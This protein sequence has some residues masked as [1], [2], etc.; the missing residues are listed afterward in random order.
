M[1][2]FIS[3]RF[4]TSAR[5]NLIPAWAKGPP[6]PTAPSLPSASPALNQGHPQP[7]HSRRPSTLGEG[8]AFKDGVA[9]A[10]SPT[11]AAKPGTAASVIARGAADR[12]PASAVT[13]GQI[14][15]V[16][17][18]I[19]SSPASVPTI[20]SATVSSF[21]PVPA[22][23]TSAPNDKSTGSSTQPPTSAT[24]QSKF[25]VKKLFAN[26]S[27]A[28]PVSSAPSQA[29]PDDASPST[30][31]SP[32]P[33]ALRPEQNGGLS[34]TPQLVPGPGWYGGYYYQPYPG[35]PPEHY[36]PS[37]PWMQAH[38]GTPH[39]QPQGLPGPPQP[40]MPMSPRNAP[41]QLHPPGTPTMAPAMPNPGHPPH[42]A[43][44]P[45]T[46]TSS[47]SSISSPPP[48]PS[49]SGP[50][51]RLNTAAPSFQPRTRVKITS[52]DGKE[53]QL[54]SFKKG[55]A[56]L[57][58]A[59]PASPARKTTVRLEKAKRE[60]P[61]R[62]KKEAVEKAEKEAEEKVT[63][64]GAEP[65]EV[66]VDE[67][68]AT[69]ASETIEKTAD[70]GDFNDKLQGNGILR[71]DAA[72][73]D[74][75]K[76]RHPGPLDLS[77]TRKPIAQTFPSAL[78][79]ARIIE[80]L[81]SV[82]Y[83]EGIRSPKVELNVNAKHGKFRYDRDFLM[84]F[85]KICKDK[86]DNLLRLDAIG[87]EP[88]EQGAG[89]PMSRGGSQRRSSAAM[90]PPPPELRAPAAGSWS[91]ELQW[92]GRQLHHGKV[93]DA[94]P[95]DDMPFE[96]RPSPMVWLPSEAGPSA[97]GSKSTRCKR[98]VDCG[99]RDKGGP[100]PSYGDS[101]LSQPGMISLEPVA[102]LEQSAN[103]WTPLSLTD[104]PEVVERRVRGLLNKLTTERF[105]SISDQIIAWANRS[106]N[107][108]DGRTLFQIMQ[109]VVESATDGVAL[110]GMYARLCRKMMNQ[111]SPK[112]QDEGIKN[113]EGKPI[114]G[115][116]LFRKYLLN[117][118][119]EDFERGWV[120]KESTAATKAA[121]DW[122]AAEKDESG[123][124]ASYS[125][126][127]YAAQ[128]ARRQ[129][130]GLIK[131][132]GELFKL[133][134]LTQRIMHKCVKEL[135]GDVENTEE[136]IEGLCMLLTTVGQL[137]DTG[138]PKAR[139]H[140]DVYFKRMKGLTKNP[141][142]NWRM[143]FMLVDLIE[144]RGRKWIPRNLATAPTTIAAAHAQAA[145]ETAANEKGYQRTLSM[146]HGGS[147]SKYSGEQSSVDLD[148]WVTGNV[149]S[150]RMSPKAGDL[151]HFGKI[152]K[153]TSI[154]IGSTG[155]P[156]A[157]EQT[158]RDSTSFSDFMENPELGLEALIVPEPSPP[159]SRMTN[160]DFAESVCALRL[161][162]PENAG[163]SHSFRE[164][165]T[166]QPDEPTDS[167]AVHASTSRA[168]Y[169]HEDDAAVSWAT[170]LSP[171]SVSTLS[172][173]SSSSLC[174]P[175]HDV[176]M[177]FG[178]NDVST[179]GNAP[180]TDETPFKPQSTSTLLAAAPALSLRTSA[181]TI[182]LLPAEGASCAG[183]QSMDALVKDKDPTL[184]PQETSSPDIE[185]VDIPKVTTHAVTVEAEVLRVSRA[186]R[187]FQSRWAGADVSPASA[188]E[189]PQ[190]QVRPYVLPNSAE[191]AGQPALQ[192]DESDVEEPD[193]LS[194]SE[195][196][197]KVQLTASMQKF[198][199]V[200]SLA[201]GETSLR[202]L[203]SAHRWRFINKLVSY[204]VFSG[205]ADSRLVSDLFSRAASEGL[206][207]PGEFDEGFSSTMVTLDVL[208]L[209]LPN[210]LSMV[211]I[212]LKG[213]RLNEEQLRRL[214]HKAAKGHSEILLAL[215]L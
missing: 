179:S 64:T 35:M 87:L 78:A 143:Q 119:K 96:G 2:H 59:V 154:T 63:A 130:L 128:K 196:Q 191:R 17:A 36:M 184:S 61:M 47:L 122:A 76:K 167:T 3:Q 4:R 86:P 37:N 178:D 12:V 134:M 66:E 187:A 101:S 165:Y 113:A 157:K 114:A 39:Q 52:S 138:T 73:S 148:S 38:V 192:A 51:S 115:G 185:Y 24:T 153:S 151:S 40:G 171:S 83:P 53:V 10:R 176:D 103:R 129:G 19:S 202:R 48:T 77:S 25:D 11:N 155:M 212:L 147:E 189:N 118:C 6:E 204:A 133:Q 69:P 166:S 137:L 80:D 149:P 124:V 91:V 203:P 104:S 13:S 70:K 164:T 102:P 132:I 163:R 161:R 183:S 158:K 5:L 50:G 127:D 31:A 93:R 56:P 207:S 107:Q 170:S 15:D 79:T 105:D 14:N 152:S 54:D 180:V 44:S 45:H 209:W 62:A 194:M 111:I 150:S 28:P 126:E 82:S 156:F 121:E 46:H 110:S 211:A 215:L 72:V 49:S 174:S 68:E 214:V 106:E 159:L 140:M 141:N 125:D 26:P 188:P 85:M 210:A 139:A 175:F 9:G 108:H 98:G 92:P 67:S 120:A 144:L 197:V 109:L 99:E 7:T 100:G 186:L 42:P 136:E 131:F 112:V 160:I 23:P 116:Q 181:S 142:V 213:T 117:R 75:P 71:I 201:E 208:A 65:D 30:R 123:E 88:S 8:V 173:S 205:A 84:Q 146:S 55:S 57:S 90:G 162:R 21:G 18:F 198:F 58:P 16:S 94:E 135:L 199:E 206:C 190:L 1:S 81:G 200:R 41:P 95:E 29:P 177:M 43:P 27:S 182:R 172:P 20:K 22:T 169:H 33:Q 168:E 193:V 89:V 60:A 97:M 34:P 195:E 145:K 32:L 74:T